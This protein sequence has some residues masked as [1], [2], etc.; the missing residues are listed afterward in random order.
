[1][2]KWVLILIS[3]VLLIL[4]NSLMPFFAIKGAYPSLLFVFAIAYSIING[5]SEAVFIGVMTGLMQD[6]F[7]YNGFGINA[8]INM[9]ICLIAAIIGENIYREKKL[10]P[11]ISVIFLYILKVL[12]V[13][14]I[15]KFMGKS[16]DIQIGM[17]TALYSSVV[18]FLGYN[19]VL[20]LYDIEY[21][22]KSWRFK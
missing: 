2:K 14:T 13:F 7:F 10:I 19:F 8:L 21:K 11:V 17:F 16:I 18:M 20:R 22:K 12:A 5:K 1:M 3:L 15:F 4:D 9:L 6:V